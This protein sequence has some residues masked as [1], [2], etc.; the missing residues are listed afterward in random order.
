MK[1]KFSPK[2]ILKIYAFPDFFDCDEFTECFK[3]DE[4]KKER[5]QPK[6]FNPF[7]NKDAFKAAQLIVD[8][9]G[10]KQELIGK[11]S[12]YANLRSISFIKEHRTITFN[13]GRQYGHNSIAFILASGLSVLG[14]V[15]V[16]CNN[17]PELKRM[18]TWKEKFD[19]DCNVLITDSTIESIILNREESDF[20]A[21]IEP[22][23][24][25]TEEKK[26]FRLYNFFN[27]RNIKWHIK[28]G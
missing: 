4:P 1:E 19:P 22:S 5:R 8:A 18:K 14:R 11:I 3:K 12:R 27:H 9:L 13:F 16:L 7:D 26:L 17:R 24:R 25:Q 28:L 21:I 23:A 10:K 15:I 20:Y 6:I 2:T